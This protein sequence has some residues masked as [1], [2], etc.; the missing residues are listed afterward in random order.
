MEEILNAILDHPTTGHA[1]VASL[2]SAGGFLPLKVPQVGYA[3]RNFDSLSGKIESYSS[4]AIR[5]G[6]LGL[7]DLTSGDAV[8]TGNALTLF[9]FSVGQADYGAKVEVA[10]S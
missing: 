4:Q 1:T 9:P 8:V 7:N 2:R 10:R 5:D 6:W 3:D